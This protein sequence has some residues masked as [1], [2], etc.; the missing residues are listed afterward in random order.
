MS[1]DTYI[2]P[3]SDIDQS[4]GFPTLA[5]RWDPVSLGP[6]YGPLPCATVACAN[7]L[8]GEHW[9]IV[10][11]PLAHQPCHAVCNDC[12]RTAGRSDLVAALDYLADNYIGRTYVGDEPLPVIEG[13]SGVEL[14]GPHLL[15]SDDTIAALV[16]DTETVTT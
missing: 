1:D 12:A 2:V 3:D 7:N 14:V 5:I 6:D 13:A 15:V 10:H 11:P 9:A 16:A 8:D 4:T